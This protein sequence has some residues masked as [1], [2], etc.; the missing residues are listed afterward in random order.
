ML[1]WGLKLQPS[2]LIIPGTFEGHEI[3][4]GQHILLIS[5]SVQAKLGMV[6]DVRDGMIW[7][8]DYEG[9]RLEVVRQVRSGLF[10]IRIDHFDN[11]EDWSNPNRPY[12]CEAMK[13]C[14]IKDGFDITDPVFLS[15]SPCDVFTPTAV[16]AQQR[17]QASSPQATPTLNLTPA[18]I[19]MRI[20]NI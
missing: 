19:K 20:D 1:P 15:K 14:V 18:E 3:P 17:S 12:A 7:I 9:Q 16:L 11:P 6:K 8:K 5:Q 10:M 13:A 2:K 4:E